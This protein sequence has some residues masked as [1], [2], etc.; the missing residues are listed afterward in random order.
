[1][2]IRLPGCRIKSGMTDCPVYRWI[3]QGTFLFLSCLA[4]LAV[5]CASTFPPPAREKAGGTGTAEQAAQSAGAQPVRV[6][7]RYMVDEN[8]KRLWLVGVQVPWSFVKEGRSLEEHRDFTARLGGRAREFYEK[9]YSA[10][11]TSEDA[12]RIRAMGANCIRLITVFW[13]FEEEPYKYSAEAFRML[14]RVIEECGKKGILVVLSCNS[15]PGGQNPQ[16]HGGAAGENEFWNVLDYQKRY[17]A[18]WKEIASHYKDSRAIAGYDVMNEP[19]PPD[20]ASLVRAYR[21][22]V[23]SIRSTGDRHVIFL[24][25]ALKAGIEPTALEGENIAYSFH[26]YAPTEF[27]HQKVPGTR[28]PGTIEGRPWNRESIEKVVARRYVESAQRKGLCLWVGEFGAVDEA[29]EDDELTW[30]DDCIGTWEKFG[31]GW[32]YYLYKVPNPGRS[33]SIYTA[34]R[35][36]KDTLPV[37]GGAGSFEET[38]FSSLVT[39]NFNVNKRLLELLT[40][41]MAKK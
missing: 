33:F 28:Y 15:A 14:D 10:W 26:Y 4:V 32:C 39:E 9:G 16:R 31:L 41:R 40:R 6:D 37:A 5:S 3:L 13:T 12:E 22:I 34:P 2:R 7:G 24:Q 20:Q 8:G 30:I 18:M 23:D 27:T 29:P 36:T 19:V 25:Y 38:S 35:D 11:F 21:D 17:S 1:M